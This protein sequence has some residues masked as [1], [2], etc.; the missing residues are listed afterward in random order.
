VRRTRPLDL[1]VPLILVGVIVWAVLP[2]AYDSLPPLSWFLP[3]PLAL[4]GVAELIAAR[5]VR[6]AV[7]HE[8]WARPMTAI[9][10]A[11]CVALGKASSIVGAAVG[12]GTIGLLVRLLP[13]AGQ[14]RAV[15]HDVE[16]A[17]AL[18]AACVLV[19]VA[20]LLLERA[21]VDPNR[22]REGRRGVSGTSR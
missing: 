4:L 5:R 6:G 17:A 18:L 10:I 19:T 7:R 1:L 9:A 12:G 14:I 20:G 13:D 2:S 22:D 11:R 21:G 15:A 16:V 3:V 8:P